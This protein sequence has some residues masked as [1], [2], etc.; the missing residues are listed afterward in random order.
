MRVAV[1]ASE[2]IGFAKTGGLAD[3]CGAL[4]VALEQLGHDVAVFMP[5]YDVV[6]RAG[7]YQA[8]GVTF[9][10]PIGPHQITTTL[11]RSTLPHSKV[12][13]YLIA[14]P[15]YFE[16]DN[17]AFGRGIYQFHGSDGLRKDYPDNSIRF[18]FF[19]RAVLEAFQHLGFW[20][21]VLHA[22]DWQTGLGPVLLREIYAQH[23]VRELAQRY[24]KIRSLFT[25][26]N[27]AYQGNFWKHDLNAAQLNWKLF[28]YKQLE[29]H[30]TLSYLKGGIVFADRVN[31]VSPTYASEIQTPYYGYGMQSILQEHS[32]KLSGI[33]NG[34]DYINWDPATDP[35]LN[36]HFDSENI[37]PGKA[38]CKK[39]LQVEL[40]LQVDNRAPLVG[41]IARLVSQK[42]L[43]LVLEAAWAMMDLG[44]QFAVL[45]EGDAQYHQGLTFLRDR[46]PNRI[47]LQFG[48]SE[49]LAHRIES[50]AD[51]FLMPSLY[52]P[53]GLNQLYSMRYGTLPVVR[54][55]GGLADTVTDTNPQTIADRSATGFSFPAY[56]SQSLLESTRRA[57]K[58]YHD[59]KDVWQQV[60]Q[61]AMREDWSWSRSARSYVDLYQSMIG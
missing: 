29:F 27:I 50:G 53:S 45:G 34:I 9:S 36:A 1:A 47:A 39:S 42:G 46:Y 12:P 24:Q 43:D 37:L 48:F 16:R 49:K 3:V 6:K 22:N 11:F 17:Q 38:D 51:L 21:D 5:M 20:P 61:N 18:L 40:G 14:N 41:M 8:T 57:V 52:E 56:N 54:A 35:F 4:P 58:L 7:N 32:D 2:V 23:P 19:T 15:E 10:V 13:V 55:T 30:D 31:T 33:V 26:H 60:Q 44:I 25:I 59:Q 28:N